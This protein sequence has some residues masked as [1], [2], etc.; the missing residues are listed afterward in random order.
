MKSKLCLILLAMLS[1]QSCSK[2]DDSSS[3]SGVTQSKIYGWWY[4]GENEPQLYHGY[5]FGNEDDYRQ[6][7]SDYGLGPGI[8]TWGWETDTSIRIVPI[9]GMYN[10]AV[11]EVTKLTNDSLVGK[12]NGG[13][14]IKLSRTNHQE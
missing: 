12:V 14:T 8:G 6:E 5:Y 7:G 4:R 11:L 3:D 9:S 13:R 2:D 1:L 10:E